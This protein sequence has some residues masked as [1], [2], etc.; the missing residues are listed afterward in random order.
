METDRKTTSDPLRLLRLVRARRTPLSRTRGVRRRKPQARSEPAQAH[1]HHPHHHHHHHPHPHHHHH[2][3][4]IIRAVSSVLMR[5]SERTRSRVERR[6]QR[7][8]LPWFALAR[9][10][11]RRLGA[12]GAQSG[13]LLLGSWRPPRCCFPQTATGRRERR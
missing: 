1:H 11:A 8:G 13:S 10:P 4:I 3:I 9:A 5:R 12:K 2:I 7:A 6:Q